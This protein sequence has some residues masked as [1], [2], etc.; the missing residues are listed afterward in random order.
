MDIQQRRQ[1]ALATQQLLSQIQPAKSFISAA[2]IVDLPA[3]EKVINGLKKFIHF[4]SNL[5][6][7]EYLRWWQQA[8]ANYVPSATQTSSQSNPAVSEVALVPIPP[9]ETASLSI[10]KGKKNKRSKK[11]Q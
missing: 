5:K 11:A 7:L 8:Y 4:L 6:P 9:M 10:R 1:R 2:D 3:L